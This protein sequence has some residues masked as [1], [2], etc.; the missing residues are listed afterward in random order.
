MPMII[1]ALNAQMDLKKIE[2]PKLRNPNDVSKIVL[3]DH[4]TEICIVRNVMKL[5]NYA[6]LV[7]ITIVL[8]ALMTLCKMLQIYSRAPKNV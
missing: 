2:L 8:S 4:L 1:I 3:L 7:L 5:A 6:R